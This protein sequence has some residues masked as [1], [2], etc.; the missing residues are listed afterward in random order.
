MYHS[1]TG[2]C[3][4]SHLMH[5]CLTPDKT[6]S[7]MEEM[8]SVD[9]SAFGCIRSSIPVPLSPLPTPSPPTIKLTD[10]DQDPTK[11]LL[12]YGSSNQTE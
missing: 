3:N 9:Y 4:Q 2:L 8:Q 11:Q 6:S 7:D 5:G 1:L 10:V 12:N